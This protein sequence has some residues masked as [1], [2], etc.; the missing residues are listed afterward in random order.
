MPEKP[1]N[2]AMIAKLALGALVLA[3]L[4]AAFGLRLWRFAGAPPLPALL[5]GL[6]DA[7]DAASQQAFVT[8]QL[9]MV[10]A[11]FAD[12]AWRRDDAVLQNYLEAL[13]ARCNGPATGPRSCSLISPACGISNDLKKNG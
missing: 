5:Q 6:P 7:H 12:G 8:Q 11:R 9:A 4:L 1:I 13:L 10:A 2:S 3:A